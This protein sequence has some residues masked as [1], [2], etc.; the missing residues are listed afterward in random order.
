M[1]LIKTDKYANRFSKV[2]EALHLNS[3][4][5]PHD[6]R[7]TFITMAKKS[8]MDEYALKR[9]VGHKIE[10]ITE[11]TYTKRDIEWLRTDIEKIKSDVLI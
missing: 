11:S 6:P 4:H 8:G 5:R 9:V 7:T 10:D 3:E 2:M 1:T